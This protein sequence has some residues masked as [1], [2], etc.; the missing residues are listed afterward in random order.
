MTP[1]KK[2]KKRKRTRESIGFAPNEVALA[3]DN[4]I[5]N[6]SFIQELSCKVGAYSSFHLA[7]LKLK[8][9]NRKM[10]GL[11][12]TLIVHSLI[13]KSNIFIH[14]RSVKMYKLRKVIK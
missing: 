8:Q 14:L 7:K 4:N 12:E 10:Q 2:G 9:D 3:S 5:F 1:L 6:Q 11:N 13:C